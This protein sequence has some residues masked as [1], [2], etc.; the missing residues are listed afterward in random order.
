MGVFDWFGSKNSK[1]IDPRIDYGRLFDGST[2]GKHSLKL[3]DK[4]LV[5][6]PEK[7]RYEHSLIMGA[8]GK[9]KTVLLQ[10][11]YV[12]DILSGAGV[13][14]V[15]PKDDQSDFMLRA[16]TKAN[17]V[18]DPE[19]AGRLAFHSFRLTESQSE[20][21]NPLFGKD[22]IQ[23]ANRLHTALFA[24]AE[25]SNEFYQ[26]VASN[27]LR[28]LISLL[29]AYNKPIN[30]NDVYQAVVDDDVLRKVVKDF[31]GNEQYQMEVKEIRTDYLEGR[32]DTAEKLKIGLRVKLQPLIKST[33][34]RLINSY[35]PDI[36]VEDII[37]RGDI[38]H[39]G[40][41]S[42]ILGK[43]NYQPLMRLFLAEVKQAAGNRYRKETKKP[44]FFYCDEY[45]DVAN[46]DFLDGIK[47]YRSAGIGFL[48]GFQDIGDLTRRGE[49]FMIQT[50][51]NCATKFIFNLPEPVSA[52]YA[53]K[54]FGT[55]ESDKISSQSYNSQGDVRGKSERLNDRAF[56]IEP[57]FLKN[58]ARG[59]CVGL[60]PY[61]H[62]NEYVIFKF[63]SKWIK[64]EDYPEGDMDLY[65]AYWINFPKDEDKGLNVAS[66]S[67]G[68]D[69]A[70][71]IKSGPQDA[72]SSKSL[73]RGTPKIKELPDEKDVESLE[74]FFGE[75]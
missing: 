27:M 22:P 74:K 36:I 60:M 8:S 67:S 1:G 30:M 16:A 13:I 9:G 17:R 66:W 32:K 4:P 3:S 64:K 38:L 23:I 18:I 50:V 21:W 24:D 7:F 71:D 65:R 70:L 39:F 12:Q 52:D 31:K 19:N 73:K 41:A 48:I 10:N 57:D 46:D 72:K 29:M 69:G 25:N 59:Q 2:L 40:L 37:S 15:D 45:G 63:R 42:D 68:S 33:W 47:K 49:H 75:N 14:F 43:S 26:D 61:M 5:I 11:M 55:Y 51:T 44:C 20:T 53:A 62:R 54:I 58:M 56:K 34:S 6:L 35:E 28:N